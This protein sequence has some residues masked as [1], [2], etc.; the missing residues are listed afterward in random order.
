MKVFSQRQNTVGQSLAL[1]HVENG[2]FAKQ[3]NDACGLV[4]R[5]LVSN[6]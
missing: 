5:A 2:I 3:G 4:L 6:L 1:L